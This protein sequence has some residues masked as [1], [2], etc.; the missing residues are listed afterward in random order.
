VDGLAKGLN[1]FTM[2]Y[3]SVSITGKKLCPSNRQEEAFEDNGSQTRGG[4]L[5]TILERGFERGQL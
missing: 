2:G 1:Y 4:D 5:L 3:C